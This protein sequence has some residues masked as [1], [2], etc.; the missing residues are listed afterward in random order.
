M[1]IA[2]SF[3][4]WSARDLNAPDFIDIGLRN[5]VRAGAT[6]GP[7][8]LVSVHAIAA[9][10]GQCDFQ[11]GYRSGLFARENG[12]EEGVINGPEEGRRAVFQR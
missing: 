9:T 3:P 10:G 11:N 2:P 5:A 4:K 12:R 8:M 6:S 7:Q 1:I